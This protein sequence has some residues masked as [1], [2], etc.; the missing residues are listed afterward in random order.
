[1][2]NNYIADENSNYYVMQDGSPTKE[3]NKIYGEEDPYSP[4]K[5]LE[6]VKA[7]GNDEI[8]VD[9]KA[10]ENEII[11]NDQNLLGNYFLAIKN[12]LP[13]I[14]MQYLNENEI[15]ESPLKRKR[16]ENK[17]KKKKHKK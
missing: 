7:Y 4:Y 1:M 8:N 15:E 2:N 3:R 17:S 6:R 16:V 13:L 11:Y 9:S 5:N 14:E 10:N 12:F